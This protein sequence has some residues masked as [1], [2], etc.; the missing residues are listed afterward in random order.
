MTFAPKGNLEGPQELEQN[1]SRRRRQIL[2]RI[3]DTHEP[4][5]GQMPLAIHA[6][7]SSLI[8]IETS[9]HLFCFSFAGLEDTGYVVGID[10]QTNVPALE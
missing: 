5:A 3:I 9:D 4:I 8:M 6:A 7:N 10:G 1:S 2:W